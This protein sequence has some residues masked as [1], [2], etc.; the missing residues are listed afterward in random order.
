[1]SPGFIAALTAR[2]VACDRVVVELT[3]HV[4]IARY[5]DLRDAL[6]ALR[7]VGVRIAVDD[8]GA[9]YASF[10][11][12]LELRPDFIKLDRGIV[13]GVAI[14]PVRRAL[15][16]AVAEFARDIHATV[17]AEGVEN[18][19]E[20][21]ALR[22]AGVTCG[23]GYYFAAPGPLPIPVIAAPPR[24]QGRRIVVVD[25]DPVVR[26][27]VTAMARRAGLDVAGQASD[28]AEGLALVRVL[29]PDVVVLDLSMPV[30]DGA[31]ALPHVRALVP[32][33]C[34]VVLSGRT[35][36]DTVAHAL[37]NGADVFVAK[38]D[39]ATKLREV[40]QRLGSTSAA[41]V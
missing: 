17:I 2:D 13:R 24:D 27:L 15:A 11:H 1:V 31:A 5:D 34:V 9:G 7:R 40:F 37:A 16:A 30:L 10:Q 38:A 6:A 28:G 3:E 12:I 26:L 4:E 18:A 25:D 33:A 21:L 22:A 32:A 41:A 20:V 29:R 39:S 35:D 23:Q 14:D 8:A 19:N 36:A